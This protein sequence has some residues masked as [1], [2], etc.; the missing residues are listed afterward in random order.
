MSENPLVELAE[1][2]SYS[3]LL[4]RYEDYDLSAIAEVAHLLRRQE[5]YTVALSLYHYLLHHQDH[6]D[7]HYGIGVCYGKTYQYAVALEHLSLAFKHPRSEGANYYA[8]ILE[9]NSCMDQA[10]QWYDYALSNGYDTDLWTLS[11]YAYF[12]EKY[13]QPEA[14][15]QAYE[16]VLKLD[17]NY[18]WA[19]KRYAI[20][21]L[22]QANRARSDNALK[23]NDR[24]FQLMQS[25]LVQ[26]GNTPFMQINYLEYLIIRDDN[27]SYEQYLRSLDYEHL[28][29]PFQTV[30]DLLDYFWR[31]LRVG[32]NNPEKL[33]DYHHKTYQLQRSIHRDFDDLN[34][35]LAEREGDLDTWHHLTQ[36]LVK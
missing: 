4:N 17:P 31:Y 26:S 13:N 9:R 14:A 1:T 18:S 19:V 15:E 10:K 32:Q 20:F 2:K 33:A 34:Q 30:V 16:T 25:A 36:L 29:L 8:Y 12:L 6:A 22:R 7:F 23:E 3:E 11:H 5:S 27:V 28:A 35:Q 24:S 21:M